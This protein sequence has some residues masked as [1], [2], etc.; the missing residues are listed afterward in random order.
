VRKTR[1]LYNDRWLP[2]SS[3]SPLHGGW[4]LPFFERFDGKLQE[5]SGKLQKASVALGQGVAQDPRSSPFVIPPHR[6]RPTGH[7][8]SSGNGDVIEPDDVWWP[9]VLRKTF[10]RSRPRARL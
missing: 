7:F 3:R 5:F 2:V 9:S 8:I 6:C 1:R 10:A 4:R